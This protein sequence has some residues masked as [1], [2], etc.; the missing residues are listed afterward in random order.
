[1]MAT[2]PTRRDV[3]LMCDALMLC[4]ALLLAKRMMMMMSGVFPTIGLR[5]CAVGEPAVNG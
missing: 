5:D 1:M 2:T 4:F 3:V